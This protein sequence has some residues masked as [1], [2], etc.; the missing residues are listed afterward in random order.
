MKRGDKI[1]LLIGLRKARKKHGI[2]KINEI[3]NH[4]YQYSHIK[5]ETDFYKFDINSVNQYLLKKVGGYRLNIQ[6]LLAYGAN[7]KISH[8]MPP[9]WQKYLA[10]KGLE[11]NKF[12]STIKWNLLLLLYFIYGLYYAI[13]YLIISLK[14]IF[15][16]YIKNN[17]CSKPYVYFYDLNVNNIPINDKDRTFVDCIKKNY[18]IDANLYGHSVRQLKNSSIGGFFYNR[19]EVPVLKNMRQFKVLLVMLLKQTFKGINL[20]LSGNWVNLFM[21]VEFFKINIIKVVGS[22]NLAETYFFNNSSFIYRPLWTY[23]AEKKGSKIVM[24]FYSTNCEPIRFKNIDSNDLHAGYS[25]MSWPIYL[26]WD[27]YQANFI[28]SLNLNNNNIT[29][30]GAIDF[31]GGKPLPYSSK[32]YIAVFDVTPVKSHIYAQYLTEIKYYRN[33]IVEL[34]HRD[35]GSV[36]KN[37]D[38]QIYSKQKRL[39]YRADNNYIKNLESMKKISNFVCVD[40][41]VSPF[42]M[43]QNAAAVIAL[44]FTSP[45][46]IAKQFNVPVIY[47]D[48][49]GMV[50]PNGTAAH[51]VDLVSNVE[52]LKGWINSLTK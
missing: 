13:I 22:N 17:V 5:I 23:E 34:F 2:K 39:D 28:R 48:P 32:K 10:L 20:Y 3:L 14:K 24:Y 26:V 4:V 16:N 35:I 40:P 7:Q 52:N 45:G 9:H 31:I 41:E 12:E 25:L 33:S 29:I 47:Y 50:D 49:T 51:G 43:I 15:L 8:P 27:D 44:P 38:Y 21:F 1:L 18:S 6:I 11:I 30:V 46:A 37:T 36:I 19:F 42:Q